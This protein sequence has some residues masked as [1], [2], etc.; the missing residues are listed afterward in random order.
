MLR[1]T[2][3]RSVFSSCL[4][5]V[6]GFVVI[7]CQYLP[8]QAMSWRHSLLVHTTSESFNVITDISDHSVPFISLRGLLALVWGSTSATGSV[9]VGGGIGGG[10]G[11]A[12]VT[13]KAV[14]NDAS[15]IL[16][17]NGLE[18]ILKVLAV[19]LWYK[20]TQACRGTLQSIESRSGFDMCL[21]THCPDSITLNVTD[22]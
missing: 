18:E 4:P 12:S 22:F 2:F 17:T 8:L 3:I 20:R 6:W 1:T 5:F 21:L 11:C 15:A 7:L 14:G 19:L 16:H 13:A 10:A 9:A